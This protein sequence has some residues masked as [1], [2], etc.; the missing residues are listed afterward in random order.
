MHR[1]EILSREPCLYPLQLVPGLLASIFWKLSQHL[2]GIAEEA[3]HFHDRIISDW[4]YIA[5]SRCMVFP[6]GAGCP[7]LDAPFE[8]NTAAR[9]GQH[10]PP[11]NGPSVRTS[12]VPVFCRSLPSRSA[13]YPY[14]KPPPDRRAARVQ[15][16]YPTPP[17]PENAHFPQDIVTMNSEIRVIESSA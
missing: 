14:A 11:P 1:F 15:L 8:G 9:V 3:D 10:N 6:P 17:T 13:E 4:I 7:I 5:S 12:A 2:P 16:G